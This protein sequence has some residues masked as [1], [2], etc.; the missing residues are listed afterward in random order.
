MNFKTKALCISPLIFLAISCSNKEDYKLDGSNIP[1]YFNNQF[2]GKIEFSR[3]DGLLEKSAKDLTIIYNNPDSRYSSDFN[4]LDTGPLVYI[5]PIPYPT[6]KK[7]DLYETDVRIQAIEKNNTLTFEVR[8][9]KDKYYLKSFFLYGLEAGHYH[10]EQKLYATVLY[11][12]IKY[13]PCDKKGRNETFLI[14]PTGIS[15]EFWRYMEEKDIQ[16]VADSASANSQLTM[17]LINF[18]GC[19]T[20]YRNP[21]REYKELPA[22]KKLPLDLL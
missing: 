21:N 19:L 16:K 11:P 2:Y 9:F 22:A 3:K 17:K 10:E 14:E 20:L 12:E 4:V 13:T 1:G 7:I 5:L 8:K 15:Y 6:I 18:D